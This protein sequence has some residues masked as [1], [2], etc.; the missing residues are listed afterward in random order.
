[1]QQ[2]PI[3]IHCIQALEAAYCSTLFDS[4]VEGVEEGVEEEVEE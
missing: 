1:V 2:S 3:F 4:K